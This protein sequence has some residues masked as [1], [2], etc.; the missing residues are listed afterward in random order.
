MKNF[1]DGFGY[2]PKLDYE[3]L[4][5]QTQRIFSVMISGGW[6]TLSGIENITG[7][8]QASIS[9]QLRNLRKPRFGSYTVKKRRVG[10]SGLWEYK[11]VGT[12]K[13]RKKIKKLNKRK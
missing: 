5:K 4:A 3:R 7:D 13:I 2:D 11:L 1:Y 12:K 10:N 6:K 8:P 9:S